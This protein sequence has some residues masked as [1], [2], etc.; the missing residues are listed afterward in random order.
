MKKK[1]TIVI[2]A[3]NEAQY[4][5]NLL[6]KISKVNLS[7]YDI[8]K[9]IVL[10]DDGSTDNTK[11][12][13]KKFKK[14]KYIKQT[15]QGKGKAV[16]KGIK[17][18]KGSIVLVQDADLEYDPRDYSKLIKPFLTKKKNSSLRIKIYK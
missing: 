6:K 7:R 14:I 11:R 13:V 4:I 16:Q 9:E 12:I 15:N 18:A 3:F 8:S 1:L 2:P 5:P 10:V 17:K